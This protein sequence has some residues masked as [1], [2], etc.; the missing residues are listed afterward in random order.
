MENVVTAGFQQCG[1]CVWCGRAL[2]G[3]WASVCSPCLPLALAEIQRRLGH[4]SADQKRGLP[5]PLLDF[6]EAG[7]TITQPRDARPLTS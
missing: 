4:E 5:F 2:T 3:A 6:D 1:P 7:P